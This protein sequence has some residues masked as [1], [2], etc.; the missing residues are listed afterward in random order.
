M[1]LSSHYHPLTAAK[2]EIPQS[3]ENLFSRESTDGKT[4]TGGT[5][6]ALHAF[7]VDLRFREN[8]PPTPDGCEKRRDWRCR[9]LAAKADLA[10]SYPNIIWGDLQC[11]ASG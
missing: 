4:H 3:Y 5:N 11:L 6:D 10:G 9:A 8:L 7:A 1:L 2:V